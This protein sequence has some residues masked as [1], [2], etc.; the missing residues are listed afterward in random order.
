MGSRWYFDM[1][2]NEITATYTDFV[3]DILDSDILRQLNK[4]SHHMDISRLQHSLNVSYFSYLAAKNL[5]LDS[6]SAARAGL[7][8]DLFFYN[9]KESGLGFRHS[10]FHP[11]LALKNALQHFELN[12]KEQEIIL[13]H[14]WPVC[15]KVPRHPETYLVSMVDKY[16]ATYEAANFS[17]RAIRDIFM[18]CF[19]R[20]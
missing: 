16:C 5:G 9:K 15:T 18:R 7:L 3:K 6:R 10:V 13:C 4:C 1:E 19:A 14:M 20:A 2:Y 8:H 11:K 17:A 12:E